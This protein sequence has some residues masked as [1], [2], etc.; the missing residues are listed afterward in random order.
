VGIDSPDPRSESSADDSTSNLGRIPDMRRLLPVLCLVAFCSSL[1]AANPY[2]CENCVVEPL[3]GPPDNPMEQVAFLAPASTGGTTL[4]ITV[5]NGANVPIVGATVQVSFNSQVRTCETAM[6]TAVTTAPLG[7]CHITLMGGGCLS[8]VIGACVITVNGLEIMNLR[9]VRSPDNADH[10]SSAPDG[11]VSVADLTY[12]G[13][14][15][16]GTAPAGCHDYDNNH[17]VNVTDLTYFG[18]AFK[19]ELACVL[20]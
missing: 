14:E 18:D 7:Q 17:V 16:L 12:F 6:H 3:L 15:F 9:Y 2:P 13:D 1:A 11:R 4:T 10:T 5:R 20:R 8:G 19:R